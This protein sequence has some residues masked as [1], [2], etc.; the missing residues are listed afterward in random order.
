MTTQPKII[1]EG[2]ENLTKQFRRL[3]RSLKRKTLRNIFRRAGRPV[4][5][6]AKRN[7]VSHRRTGL[8]EENVA[9]TVGAEE[10]ATRVTVLIGPRKKMFYGRF[11]EL[12]TATSPPYPWLVPALFQAKAKVLAIIAVGFN[13]EFLKIARTGNKK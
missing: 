2:A 11:L 13:K 12:G 4:V 1:V 10:F 7:L 6:R 9:Q 5:T 8:L 3:D